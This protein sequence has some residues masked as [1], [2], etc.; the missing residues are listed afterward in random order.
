ML[1]QVQYKTKKRVFPIKIESEMFD[2]KTGSATV[3]LND[4]Q[5]DTYYYD[6]LDKIWHPKQV[7]YV[8]KKKLS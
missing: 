6:I 8:N 4:K 2:D 1:S 7:I 3:Q 5:K